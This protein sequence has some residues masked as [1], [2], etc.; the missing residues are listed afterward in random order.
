MARASFRNSSRLAAKP[1]RRVCKPEVTGSIPGTF[2]KTKAPQMRGFLFRRH[3][4]C[5]KRAS[6]PRWNN[7]W[8]G[9]PIFD[10]SLQDPDAALRSFA[11]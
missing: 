8:P 4:A 3:W 2:H 10:N 11:S 9:I 7:V 6:Q 5:S 1:K